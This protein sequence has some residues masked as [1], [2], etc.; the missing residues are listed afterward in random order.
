MVAGPISRNRRVVI[1]E[2]HGRGVLDAAGGDWVDGVGV[3]LCLGCADAVSARI[4]T[5]RLKRPKPLNE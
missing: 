4:V 1:A 3:A 5:D 2:S